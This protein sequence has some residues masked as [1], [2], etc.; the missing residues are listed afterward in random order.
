MRISLALL[1]VVATSLAPL[2]QAAPAAKPTASA[3]DLVNGGKQF[4]KCKSCH[5]LIKGGKNL[6]GPN[7]HGLFGRKAGSVTGYTY[8]PAIKASGIVW[9]DAKLDAYLANP[10][11][12]IKG[13]RMSF[14]GIKAPKDRTDLIAYLKANTK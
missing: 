1:A 2:A 10:K 6:V 3:A 13:T 4:N 14:G 12:L 7:L 8:S 11:G 5:T 9:G